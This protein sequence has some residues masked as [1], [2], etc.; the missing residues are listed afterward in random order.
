MRSM[1]CLRNIDLI[2]KR[3]KNY[4]ESPKRFKRYY[5]VIDEL[6]SVDCFY[7]NRYVETTI[8]NISGNWALFERLLN[9][10]SARL[11]CNIKCSTTTSQI[12]VS[13]RSTKQSSLQ[14]YSPTWVAPCVPCLAGCFWGYF[15]KFGNG[16]ASLSDTSTDCRKGSR[17]T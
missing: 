14:C 5:I 4:L 7:Q 1:I 8:R 10:Y 13:H 16:W 6:I 15:V 3:Q 11:E 2:H 12:S 17:V 9:S